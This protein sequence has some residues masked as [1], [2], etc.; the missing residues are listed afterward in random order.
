MP[1]CIGF[2]I[3][4]NSNISAYQVINK[5]FLSPPGIVF[6]IVWSILY[7]LLGISSVI[8]YNSNNKYKNNALLVYFLGLFFNFIWSLIFFN[9]KGYL[10]A[11]IDLILII[12]FTIRTILLFNKINKL[13]AYLLLPYFFWLIFAMYLNLG[14]YLL[15]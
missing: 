2:L 13:S 7:I 8:I 15:N 6:P 10:L 14:V 1:I 9:L 11:Y 4:I 5:P 12:I 3:G